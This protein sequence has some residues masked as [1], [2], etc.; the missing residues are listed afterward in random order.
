MNMN[1]LVIG[2]SGQLGWELERQGREQ[3]ADIISLDL[4]EFDLTDATEA[5]KAVSQ[6]DASLVIN[7]SAYTAVDRAE[8]E[9]DAAFAV[10]RDGPSHQ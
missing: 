6:S 9:P 3:G 1:L 8:S 2:S 10:N 7:A 4:P 5:K